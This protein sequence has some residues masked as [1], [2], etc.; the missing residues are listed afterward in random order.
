[1]RPS[2]RWTFT[3][4]GIASLGPLSTAA[5]A[6]PSST[7]SAPPDTTPYVRPAVPEDNAPF[8]QPARGPRPPECDQNVPPGQETKKPPPP[9]APADKKSL[10]HSTEAQNQTKPNHLKDKPSSTRSAPPDTTPYVRPAVPEDNAP[11]GQPARGPRA[12]ECDQ[13]VP[14]G[15]ETKK[16]PPPDAPADKKRP[17]RRMRVPKE[18]TR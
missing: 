12:P 9:G 17:R 4:V 18:E 8:G 5:G 14:P 15:R 16:P 13:N 1:M 10:R 6:E 3:L 2:S 11:F 7:R